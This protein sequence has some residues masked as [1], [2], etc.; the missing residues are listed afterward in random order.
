MGSYNGAECCEIVG[1]Y[2][3]HNITHKNNGIL[4]K[5]CVGLYRDDGLAIIRGG[6]SEG[7]RISKK[8][9]KLFE[10]E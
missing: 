3:L 7:E 9:F 4:H 2:L 6:A 8:L 10:K 1:L 5:E